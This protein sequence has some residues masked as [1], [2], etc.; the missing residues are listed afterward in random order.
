MEERCMSKI[1]MQLITIL[2]F[3]I[4]FIAIGH[5]EMYLE[6]NGNIG[7]G[8]S[9][10]NHKLSVN[11]TIESTTGGIKF[12]DGT[13]QTTAASGGGSG[14][15]TAVNAGT[16]LS[17]GGL[18]GDVTLNTDT[19]YLQRRVESS[20]LEG[21]SI[22]VINT[23]GTVICE[24]DNGSGG[25]I[26][27]ET[28][29]TVINS[30]KDGVSWTEVTGRPFGLD[31]GDDVGITS[32]T[33]PQVGS[34]TNKYVPKWNGSSLVSGAIYDDGNIGI[35]RTDTFAKLDLYSP[36]SNHDI[37]IYD[38]YMLWLESGSPATPLNTIQVIKSN[39]WGESEIRFDNEDVMLAAIYTHWDDRALYFLV[40]GIFD[41]G[42][43][44]RVIFDNEDSAGNLKVH[45]W[46][47]STKE[48]ALVFDKG[49]E[50]DSQVIPTGYASKIYRPANS[51]DLVVNLSGIGDVMTFDSLNGNVGIGTAS[52]QSSLQVEGYVQLALTAGSPPVS[53]CDEISERGRMKV[54]N[55]AGLLFICVDSGWIAK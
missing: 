52:P 7:I 22:R 53:D 50:F 21:S 38:A 36:V 25:G 6:S 24:A 41:G 30:V 37:W 40:G 39:G 48:S 27:A 17:G 51:Q 20:C 15:I 10:P 47:E 35:G 18:S 19:T 12:P 33:D 5:T 23:D 43:F 34:N 44:T 49:I 3:V 4:L 11:G 8:T 2:N 13:T 26:T 28:D 31:D 32:E 1:A 45:L 55:S 29:P 14:D 9:T 46:A 16:G 42:N 54:D